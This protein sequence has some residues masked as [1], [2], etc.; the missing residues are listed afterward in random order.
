MSK[1]RQVGEILIGSAV[2]SET[3]TSDFVA[4]ATNGDLQVFHANGGAPVQGEPFKI[5]M[6][7]SNPNNGTGYEWSSVIDPNKVEKITLAEYVPET[8]KSDKVT[9]TK[10]DSTTYIIEIRLYN[11]NGVLSPENFELISGYYMTGASTSDTADIIAAGLR[12]SLDNTLKRRG[13]SEFT[14]SGATNEVIITS[15]EQALIPGKMDGSPLR[16]DIR[17]KTV[18]N[19]SIREEDTGKL[20]LSSVAAGNTGKGT[21]KQV[22]TKEWFA[23]GFGYDVY[24]GT[25]YPA[26]LDPPYYAS[27]TGMYNMIVINHYTERTSP[28][29]E[30][31]YK[32]VTLAVAKA[33]NNPASNVDTNLLLADLRKVMNS[34]PADLADGT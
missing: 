2:A 4:N 13:D 32:S 11:P 1:V 14:I 7:T 22:V 33:V 29:L 6:K 17:V 31:Q 16:Y 21:G 28:T 25:A 30:R 8:Q 5:Y 9:V 18:A 3:N 12:K 15:K 19:S 34:V 10:E 23:K 26:D 24:R 20:V 27:A